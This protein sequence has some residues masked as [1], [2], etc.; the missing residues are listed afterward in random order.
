M[1]QAIVLRLFPP[2]P[3]QSFPR[4]NRRQSLRDLLRRL[5]LRAVPPHRRRFVPPSPLRLLPRS[6]HRSCQQVNPQASLQ[7]NPRAIL[8]RALHH[9]QHIN[10]ALTPPASLR[11]S[12]L[13]DHPQYPPYLQ[14]NVLLRS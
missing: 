5:L 8:H 12:P 6:L 3:P 10:P 2:S 4:V 9:I 14:A 13:R 1:R 7:A 11:L